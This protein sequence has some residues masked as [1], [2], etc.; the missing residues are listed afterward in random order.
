MKS[1]TSFFN[2]AIYKKNFYF[3]LA[4]LGVLSSVW[5]G[6]SSGKFVVRASPA[7]YDTKSAVFRFCGQLVN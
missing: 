3:I 1:K 7:S 6:K 2:K 4:N 5:S